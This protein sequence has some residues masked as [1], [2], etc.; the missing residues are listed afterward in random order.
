MANFDP[1]EALGF[2]NG[3]DWTATHA[4]TVSDDLQKC[5]NFQ[6]GSSHAPVDAVEIAGAGMNFPDVLTIVPDDASAVWFDVAVIDGG[7]SR[8]N[9]GTAISIIGNTNTI[10]IG[11]GGTLSLAAASLSTFAGQTDI[12]GDLTISGP[13]DF[14]ANSDPQMLSGCDMEWK[15]GSSVL[16]ESGS[17]IS[18]QAGVNTELGGDNVFSGNITRTSKETRS[19]VSGRTVLRTLVLSANTSQNISVEQDHVFYDQTNAT[20]HVLTALKTTTPIPDD[21]EVISGTVINSGGG[22]VTIKS[23]GSASSI[24]ADDESFCFEIIYSSAAGHWRLKSLSKAIINALNTTQFGA[25]A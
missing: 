13:T 25:D 20:P 7:T 19:G 4:N 8:H 22:V 2:T 14:G 5:A 6:D 1:L 12:T 9:F 17:E 3:D 16:F 10:G 11:A 23:E 18:V 24:A 15:S 21:G